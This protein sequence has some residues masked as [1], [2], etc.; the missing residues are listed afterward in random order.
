MSNEGGLSIDFLDFIITLNQHKV[1]YVLVGGYALAVHGI[2]RATGDID[3]LYRRTDS[4]VKRLRAALHQFGAPENV[5]DTAALMQKGIVTQLGSP[6]QR[7]DLL[8]EIDGVT[9]NEVW[10]GVL[11]TDMDGVPI[12]VIGRKELEKNKVAAGR[13]KDVLDLRELSRKR[14]AKKT[15]R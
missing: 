1:A 10:K 3:F 12:F 5:I 15:R 4:N 9:F 14:P 7:I 2:T 6:P 11:R 8:N 13:D